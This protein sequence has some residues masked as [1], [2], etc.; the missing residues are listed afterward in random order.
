MADQLSLRIHSIHLADSVNGERDTE[1]LRELASI[2]L[3]SVPYR[4]VR[5]M[6][7]PGSERKKPIS[8]VAEVF[9]P[10]RTPERGS[11]TLCSDSDCEDFSLEFNVRRG[12][13]QIFFRV[14]GQ[15]LDEHR[16]DVLD[17]MV[18]ASCRIHE[19]VDSRIGPVFNV[20]LLGSPFPRVRPPRAE[21]P[22][23]VGSLVDFFCESY[24]KGNLPDKFPGVEKM[25]SAP[26][27]T[28][29]TR[30]Y[31]GDMLVLQ[32]VGSM[33]DQ[34]AVRRQRSRQAVWMG[35]TLGLRIDSGFNEY[36][37]S[38]VTVASKSQR[39][40]LTF[41]DEFLRRGYRAIVEYP[42]GVIDEP[43]VKSMA[44]LIRAGTLAD[45]SELTTVYFIAPSRD[46][47]LRLLPRLKNIGARGVLY[48]GAD[49]ELWDPEPEG[50][51][52]KDEP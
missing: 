43:M 40:E 11:V 13:L 15:V 47:A 10:L 44:E 24:F 45:G 37:D 12:L 27:P 14:G 51:W 42:G 20:A 4:D 7:E 39:P 26:M 5:F 33:A 36:G 35:K 1:M 25:K 30:H 17:K 3:Q 29:A 19:K 46:S 28:G 52:L 8:S 2:L 49:N 23:P 9:E 41:Y 18:H 16:E 48:P 6:Q 34:F 50:D 22:W 31:C 21:P 38:V 32:W